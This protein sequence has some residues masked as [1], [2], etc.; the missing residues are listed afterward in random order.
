MSPVSANAPPHDRNVQG[1][2]HSTPIYVSADVRDF[3]NALNL[4]NSIH[5]PVSVNAPPHGQNAQVLKC[6]ILGHVS[7]SVL[8]F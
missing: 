3:Y 1:L 4:R 8:E 7:A 6:S 5:L 2:K